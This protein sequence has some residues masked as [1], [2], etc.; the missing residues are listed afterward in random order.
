MSVFRSYA[1]GTET[2]GGDAVVFEFDCVGKR[3]HV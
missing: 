3:F 2:L 1:S